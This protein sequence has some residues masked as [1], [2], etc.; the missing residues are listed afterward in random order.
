[1]EV[2]PID[3]DK[4]LAVLGALRCESGSRGWGFS[5]PDSDYDVRFVYMHPP[6]HL[7][8]LAIGTSILPLLHLKLDDNHFTI[9]DN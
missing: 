1:M 5:S 7:A 2:H 4:R 6:H 9:V 3:S 8:A